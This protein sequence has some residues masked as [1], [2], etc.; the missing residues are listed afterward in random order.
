VAS[1][2]ILVLVLEFIVVWLEFSIVSAMILPL[3]SSNDEYYMLEWALISPVIML[4]CVVNKVLKSLSKSCFSFV[5]RFLEFLGCKLIVVMWKYLFLEMLI[6]IVGYSYY[7]FILVIELSI[8][9]NNI[10]FLMKVISPPPSLFCLSFLMV[11]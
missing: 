10:S 1:N 5:V 2:G 4:F 7:V 11:V 8:S 6:F 9:V 3:V